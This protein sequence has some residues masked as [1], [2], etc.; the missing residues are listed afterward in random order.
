MHQI[1]YEDDLC[2]DVPRGAVKTRVDIQMCHYMGGNQK[3]DYRNK[4]SPWSRLA[5]AKGKPKTLPCLGYTCGFMPILETCEIAPFKGYAF[6]HPLQAII[7]KIGLGL[8][9]YLYSIV[10]LPVW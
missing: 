2:L 5:V 4:V 7:G 9:T 1:V 6:W 8:Q 10:T 3:W